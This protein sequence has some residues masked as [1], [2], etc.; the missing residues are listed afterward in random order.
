MILARG[1]ADALVAAL[2]FA[3]DTV[4]ACLQQDYEGP[5]VIHV[6]DD[7]G[8][9]KLRD[10]VES[11][12]AEGHAKRLQYI[13]REKKPGVPHHFKAGNM[14]H[15]LGLTSAP[16]IAQLDADMIPTP[17]FLSRLMAEVVAD[18]KVAYAYC[19][20]SFYNWGAMDVMDDHQMSNYLTL[21][22]H[23]GMSSVGL[24]PNG[25]SGVVWRREALAEING[26]RTESLG[27]D[28]L[29]SYDLL[30]RGWKSVYVREPMQTGLIPWTAQAWLKQ[31]HRWAICGLEQ[32]SLL[33]KHVLT[34]PH[35]NFKQK[36]LL[37]AAALPARYM[38]MAMFLGSTAMLAVMSYLW[39]ATVRADGATID[40]PLLR[41][42]LYVGV[43]AMAA[44]QLMS[45]LQY[46]DLPVAWLWVMIVRQVGLVVE[47]PYSL[48]WAF[49]FMAGRDGGWKATG[50]YNTGPEGPGLL[51]ALR[52]MAA[53]T[54]LV[55]WNLVLWAAGVAVLSVM[56]AR[57][58]KCG[59]PFWAVLIGGL[60][61][62][63]VVMVIPLLMPLYY[64]ACCMPKPSERAAMVPR[65][66]I[67]G[68]PTID[69]AYV[70][71][72]IHVGI[73]TALSIPVVVTFAFGVAVIV[74]SVVFPPGYEHRLFC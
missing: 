36:Y 32:C 57:I 6:L 2:S 53:N 49:C 10:W 71:P 41:I 37:L 43:A 74:A 20:Q 1:G 31:H 59:H 17:N 24:G 15:A 35:L 63:M 73:V 28:Y 62:T 3:L 67:S 38:M 60:L 70:M 55:G 8:D 14:N 34:S 18:P 12:A 69:P 61:V 66:P 7:G 56:T 9:D 39:L 52:R 42:A 4:L 22:S 5:Y 19:P 33:F 72:K 21:S 29:T 40:S 65:D 44:S 45:A 64:Y 48:W 26:F 16:Y 50:K 47:A 27:E 13:R 68:V 23:C 11:M 54:W 46:I 30:A 25:G 58:L 51:S